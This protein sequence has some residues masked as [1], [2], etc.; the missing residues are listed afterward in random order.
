[1]QTFEAIAATLGAGL[2][3][4][5]YREAKRLDWPHDAALDASKVA[6]RDYGKSACKTADELAS[7]TNEVL[8]SD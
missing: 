5:V 7:V 4:Q 2:A 1:M 6:E 8:R 3:G